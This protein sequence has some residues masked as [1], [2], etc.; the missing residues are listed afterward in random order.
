MGRGPTVHW[1]ESKAQVAQILQATL[2]PLMES[3]GFKAIKKDGS[4]KRR[5][6]G[7]RN[8]ISTTTSDYSPRYVI[9]F[10]FCITPLFGGLLQQIAARS[11]SLDMEQAARQAGIARFGDQPHLSGRSRVTGVS[12]LKLWAGHLA[13]FLASAV[14]PIAQ[15]CDSIEGLDKLVNAS[16]PSAGPF[17]KLDSGVPLAYAA[18]NPRFDELAGTPHRGVPLEVR[19]KSGIAWRLQQASA[20]KRNCEAPPVDESGRWSALRSPARFAGSCP[21]R[22]GDT[23]AVAHP[24]DVTLYSPLLHSPRPAVS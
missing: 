3:H 17:K 16:P 19:S 4:F 1:L 21:S 14:I 9:E 15:R 2:R 22:R 20:C 8:S 6:K 5:T 23:P 18:K 7:K 13:D 11:Y 12:G 24:G 10:F